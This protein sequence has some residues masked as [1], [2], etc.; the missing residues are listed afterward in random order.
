[1]SDRSLQ[2]T[3]V[4]SA[5]ASL[6]IE[7][8][9]GMLAAQALAFQH[10]KYFFGLIKR[11]RCGFILP[12]LHQIKRKQ[13]IRLLQ[14][15]LGAVEAFQAEDYAR[16]NALCLQALVEPSHAIQTVGSRL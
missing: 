16:L 14:L 5:A 6:C 3:L 1:M 10:I 13:G 7:F 11:Q 2:L 4:M 8:L 12:N 15:V 9:V